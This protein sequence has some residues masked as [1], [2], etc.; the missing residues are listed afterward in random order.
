M[1]FEIYHRTHYAYAAPVRD[2]FNEVRLEPAGGEQQTVES[3][4]L[5]IMPPVRLRHYRDFY[6]NSVNHFDIPEPHDSLTIESRLKITTHP[7][8]PLARDARTAT[9]EELTTAVQ[10]DQLYD[11]LLA[12]QYVDLDSAT[13]RLAVD[14]TAGETDA[15]QCAQCVMQFVHR[16]L[17]YQP[18]ATQVHTHMREV[19]A[20]RQGV[21]QDYAHVMIGFCRALRIPARYVSGYLATETAS[22]TH[23]WTEVYVPAHGWQA[24]DPTHNCQPGETYVKIG[25][26]RDY[27]DVA[28]IRGTYKGTTTRRM[29]VEVRIEKR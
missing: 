23:A 29:E 2:S 17:T 4:L 11:F 20:Q 10:T 14:A 5:K 24:L 27:S 13:W 22:A 3:F 25:V 1:K 9:P 18:Q 6:F 8:P 28:P 26:G 7:K 19:L 12:S 15:W 16:H 21:C